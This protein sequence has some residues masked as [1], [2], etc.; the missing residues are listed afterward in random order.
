MESTGRSKVFISYSRADLAFI[1]ELVVALESSAEFEILID[2]IGIGHGE[3]W[4]ERLSR[5]IVECD[6]MVFVLSPDSVASEVCAWEIAEA[7]RLAKRVIPILWR[8]VDFAEVPDDL[9]AINAVPFDQEHAVSG[10]PKLVVALKS[11]L[12]WLREH[13]R[14]G[15][16]AMEWDLSGRTT[17]YLLRGAALVS[18]REWL[19]DKPNNAPAPTELQRAYL[20]ASEAEE[21]RLLSDERKRLVELEEAKAI[22]EEERDTA[23]RA[24]VG[25]AAAAQRVV[26]AT[27]IGLVVAL[28]LLVAAS[29]AGWIA[30]QKAQDERVAAE[31][32]DL[33]AERAK[34]QRDAALLTQSRFLARAARTYLARGDVA[35]A[36]GLARAALPT[37]LSKPDRPPAIEALQVVFDAYG[38]LRELAALRGH[39]RALEG[40]LTLP[41]ER[42]ITWGRDGTMRWWRNDGSLVKVVTAHEHPTKPGASEDT[43][44]HGVLRLEDGRLLSWGVDKTA[45][46]WNKDGTFVEEFLNET[47][48]IHLERLGDGRIG[49]LIGN[50]YRI[51]NAALEPLVVLRSPLKWMR[52]ARLLDDGRFLTWQ[53]ETGKRTHTAMLWNP[54]GSLGPVLAGHER[55]LRGGFQLT[56]GRLVTFENGPSL[57]IW[58][59]DGELETVIDKAHKHVPFRPFA[60]PLRDGRFFTWG[61]EAYHDNV[62]WARLWTAQ[63][64][65]VPL[66]EASS[67]PLQ[68][69]ELD[70]SRLLLGINSR[71]PTIWSTDGTR[72]T[73]LRG[74]EEPAHGAAQWP[75]GRIVTYGEDRTAR[76]WN[77]DGLP[78]LLLRGHES[79]VSG[80]EP[81]SGERYLSWSF[82]DRTARIWGDAPRPRSLLRLEGGDAKKV[83]QL[84]TGLI[85]V[86]SDTGSVELYEPDLRSGPVLRNDARAVAD[87]IEMTDGR[88]LTRG[89]NYRNSEPGPALRM[90]SAA[91][92]VVVDLAGSDV[93]FL[94]VAQTPSGRIL[95]VDHSGHV[96]IWR[97]DGQPESKRRRTDAARFYQVISMPDGRFATVGDDKHLV[98]WSA[99]G[100]PSQSVVMNEATLKQIVSFGDGRILMIDGAALPWISG[101]SGERWTPLDLGETAHTDTAIPLHD[102]TILLNRFGDPPVIVKSDGS[103][104]EMLDPSVPDDRHR[105]KGIIKL[106][107]GRLL[108]SMPSRGTQ[109]WNADGTPGRQILDRAISGA[110]LLDD[111]SFLVWPA[112][113]RYDLQII[114]PDG[115]PG[116]VLQGHES[117]TKRAFQLADGRILSWAEDA[118]VRIW[119]GSTD[120]AVAW[121]DDVIARL[122]PLTIE[123]RCDHY[124]EP[125]NVCGN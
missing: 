78:L 61:Q 110:A 91:G 62:W 12:A 65:S 25:E 23:E 10:L 43:G 116:P 99:E 115:E 103:I 26:R 4:R 108:V 104:R 81:L 71:T 36:I 49:A 1:D 88:F 100:E 111:G 96:W 15:E 114:Q 122:Q 42:I 97:S 102:G 5:L 101:D 83:Q 82:G 105:R 35:N 41:D 44:V 92:E 51:W 77:R 17:A 9:S 93:A 39:T 16:K 107:D 109:V 73:M 119:P 19:A 70:D 66:I 46:L 59:S 106:E 48:W 84:S 8:A 53:S 94:H 34:A 90:W 60:F 120:Q 3:A 52:G 50:E 18:A 58:S 64:D 56:D 20:Q 55:M 21:S 98:L 22:A 32:A 123:E 80:I 67:S 121:A 54:D 24:R 74:H 7:R 28:V 118:T 31:R 95:A 63:G 69:L 86:H 79:G 85:A 27:T 57:R 38:K 45:K 89:D 87:L 47:S 75:D 11:D 72:G 13:T 68:A 33:A 14:I 113:E 40:V 112:N 30:Y 76:I 6:S 117:V 2:R 125:K 29:G 124:L 37:D